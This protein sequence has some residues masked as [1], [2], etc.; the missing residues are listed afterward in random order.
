MSAEAHNRVIAIDGPD[1]AGKSSQV[2]LLTEYF[3]MQGQTV[4]ATRMSGGTPIGEAL[5]QVSLN[6]DLPRSGQTDFYISR[7]M[8]QALAEDIND[9]KSKEMIIIDRSP[10]AM[11][12]YNAFASQMTNKDEALMSCLDMVKSLQ[13][14]TLI[15]LTAAQSILDKRREAR[16]NTDYFEKKGSDYHLH[17]RQG[18]MAGLMYLKQS[19]L[20]VK[21]VEINAEPDKATVHQN[22]LNEL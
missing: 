6:D 14:D 19:N 22:I 7:A 2:K 17:V 1:G 16:G 21:V 11:V 18:Y 13:I 9:R 4:H 10:L 12:A 3:N 8:C 5:R 15:Y 20:G